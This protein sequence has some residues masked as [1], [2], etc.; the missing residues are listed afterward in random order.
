M[1]KRFTDTA[2]WEKEWFAGLSPVEK[3][4]WFYIKDRC[5]PVGVW[6]PSFNIANFYLGEKLDWDAFREK[7]NGNINVLANGKWW[8]VDFC[9]YQYGEL[10]ENSKAPPVIS[11]IKLLKK[12]G[13]WELYSKGIDTLAIPLPKGSD[14]PK[15]KEI[16]RAHV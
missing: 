1:S 2:L 9:R 16:G 4:A 11:Y 14:T 3:C 15:D 12:H 10:D 13:L 5:D 8:L 7:C 6:E